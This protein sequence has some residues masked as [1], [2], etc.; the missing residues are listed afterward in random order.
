MSVVISGVTIK[1]QGNASYQVLNNA[2][3]VDDFN[4]YFTPISVNGMSQS[5]SILFNLS[6][7]SQ[8]AFSSTALP[9]FLNVASFSQR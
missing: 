7:S 4:G 2:F 1:S 8:T 5:G 9:L 6:D 3:G